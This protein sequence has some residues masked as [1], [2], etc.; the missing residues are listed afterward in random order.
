MKPFAAAK[1]ILDLTRE[2]WAIDLDSINW[3]LEQT[4]DLRCDMVNAVAEWR[5]EINPHG[6]LHE[7]LKK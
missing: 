1:R 2:G 5:K 7:Q 6:D 3:A 4:G